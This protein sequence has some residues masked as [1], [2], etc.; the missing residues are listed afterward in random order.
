MEDRLLEEQVE[1]DMLDNGFNPENESHVK[2]YWK[3]K[4][5]YQI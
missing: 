1:Q 3:E 5:D 2:Q 4:L